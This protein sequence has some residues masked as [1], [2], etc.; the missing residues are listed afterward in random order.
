MQED[1]NNEVKEP[2]DLGVKIMDK[3][4]AYWTE[5]LE[6]TSKDVERLEKMLR[7]NLEIIGLCKQKL[8]GVQENDRPNSKTD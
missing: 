6:T 8:K 1:K 2:E 5:I 3:E 4:E 7:F